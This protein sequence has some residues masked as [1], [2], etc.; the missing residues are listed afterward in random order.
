MTAG[1][2][3]FYC[4]VDGRGTIYLP[5]L[6]IES[7]VFPRGSFRDRDFALSY[8]VAHEWAHHVQRLLGMFSRGWPSKRIELQ[9]DCLAG[10]WAY[11]VWYRNLLE[12]GD[13]EEAVALAD[14]VGDPPG[15][16]AG[17]DAH[18][19][20]AQRKKAFLVGYRTGNP[21]KC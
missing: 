16:P 3:P 20:G 8:V 19:T 11:S 4:A 13:V 7:L 6:G 12:P 9:A 18:G 14:L 17:R 15:V 5:L 1:D 10:V 2:G 21:S